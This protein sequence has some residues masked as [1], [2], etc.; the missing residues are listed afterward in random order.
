VFFGSQSK[1]PTR[2]SNGVV[3]F[4]SPSRPVALFFGTHTAIMHT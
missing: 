4:F 2:P 1:K 3:D